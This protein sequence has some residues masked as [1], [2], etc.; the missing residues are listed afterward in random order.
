MN[1]RLVRVSQF[2]QQFNLDV[3]H[4]PGKEHII[5]DA[6]SRLA[7]TNVGCSDPFHSE[8]DALFT[9]NATLIEIHPNLISRILAGYEDDEY[10]ARLR[11]QV[12][13]NEDLGDDK[14]VLP[15]I[16]GGSYRSDSDPYMVPRPESSANASSEA[17]SRASAE[18]D[19]AGVVDD[20]TLPPP[21]KTK[22]LYQVN[23]TTG[24]LRLCIP[25]TVAPDILQITH[26]EGH[27]GFSRCY[28]IITRSWYIRG[29][30]KLLR[31]FIRHC[32]QYLQLQTR[33]HRPYGSL[34]PIKSPPIPFFMLMLDFVLA[35]PLTK[36]GYNTIMSVTCKFSKRVTLI[37]GA[38]TWSA[39]QW[40]Q[41]FLKRLDLIDWGLPGELITDRDPKFLS[42]F[43]AELFARLGVKLL[44][45]T[46]YHPQ[47]DGSS[48]R[49]NQTVEIAL[50]FFV[51]A[52]EDA[53]LW[54]EV[55]PRIQ[56]ILNNT[57]SSTTS[58]TPNEVAYSFSPRRP[59]DLL[60]DPLLPNILQARTDATDAI[61]F[62]LANQKA[63]YDRKHQ[64]LFM[65]VGDWAMLKLHKGY[66][67]PSSA[68]VTKKLTQQYVGPFRILEKVGRLAYKLDV[69]HDWK[70]HPVF[71]VAQ[72]EP[73]PL[74]IKDPFHR[75]RP[76]MPPAVFVD[77]DIDAVKSFE[78][79]RLLNKRIVRKGKG[80]AVEYLVR[81]TRYGP[82][83]DRWYNIKDL[84]NAADL[85]RDYEGALA[86]R[87]R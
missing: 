6:L 48:K 33:Q 51:H 32:P 17:T 31:E 74:P 71:S 46:A 62:A 56:S 14:A 69:L 85:V 73:A 5:P 55:L 80:R 64:P 86:Q 10:W 79:D 19:T 53:S 9:Y 12:Q 1:L 23:R 67:I 61:S 49:T 70:I 54:L 3:R 78:V 43:W 37:E 27:P 75:P 57:S 18:R 40:A 72:L 7:S 20:P 16:T 39:E 63:H 66:S 58:K 38:D 21:D 65:K 13:A 83:W 36:Q 84:D 28:E 77:D 29:L 11:R 30:T 2:L 68:G 24:N 35:L 44:Y 45:S 50:H 82:E 25:P 47:I 59:L 81:W 76:H 8:L 87:G 42:R 4:K 41:A 34:Q 26:G 60:S 15:F 22:L 52:L